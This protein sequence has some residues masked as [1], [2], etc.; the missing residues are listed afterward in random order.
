MVDKELLYKAKI[1]DLERWYETL[2][3][4]RRAPRDVI[5]HSGGAAVLAVDERMRVPMVKQF[6]VATGGYML[7]IPAGKLDATDINPQFAAEREL[8]EEC[9][10]IAEKVEHLGSFYATPGYCTEVIHL[11]LATGLSKGELDLDDGEFLEV[12]YILLTTLRV[13]AKEGRINDMKTALAISL[14]CAKLGL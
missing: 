9:G 4:G 1:L 10:V 3:D 11:Y 12:E 14:A 7:E 8:R 13:M 5:V 6:R 2:P